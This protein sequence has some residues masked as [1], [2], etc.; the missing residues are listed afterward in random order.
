M[1]EPTRLTASVDAEAEAGLAFEEFFRAE[2]ERLFQAVY[3]LSGDAHEADDVT[4]EALVRAY[5]R[6]DVVRTMDSP[7]GYVYRTALNL[8]R[9]RLRKLAVRARRVF[10][11]V[12]SDDASGEVAARY[13]VRQAL[14]ALPGAQ[15]EALVL[16]EWLGLRSEEAGLV[17]GIDASSVRGR[18]HR[19]RASL[20]QMLGD[21]DE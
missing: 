20:R 14:A 4:Q 5:E 16:I 7:V 11:A 15:R 21:P 10:L 8:Y 2:H 19:G 1:I 12:P 9:S 6:W 18:L 3:L 17:L 13:D